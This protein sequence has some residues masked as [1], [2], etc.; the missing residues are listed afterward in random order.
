MR[1]VIVI[2]GT[3]PEAIKVVSVVHELRKFPESFEV[4]LCSTGQHREMLTQ[5]FADFDMEP[6]IHLDVMAPNQTLSGLSARLFEKLDALLL[7]QKPH[8]LLVQGDTTSVQVAS[9]AAFYRG[10]PVGHIE[11]G[12]RSHTIHSPFPEELNRRI[13]RPC[14]RMAFCAYAAVAAESHG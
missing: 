12:L 11:A 10:I 1:K 7:E 3:R 13:T 4:L 6:D 8:M 14:R 9:L 5:T 2:A